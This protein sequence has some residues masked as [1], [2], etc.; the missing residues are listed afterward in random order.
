MANIVS[1]DSN[2]I[3]GSL[4]A[5]DHV[6]VY[7][8]AGDGK[9]TNTGQSV[10]I[11]GG[12]SDNDVENTGSSATIYGDAGND[13]LVNTGSSAIIDGGS[14]NDSIKSGG[15]NA[16]IT[17]GD[18][19]DVI[20][21][22][23]INSTIS[24]GDGNDVFV[25][26]NQNADLLIEDYSQVGD[27]DI[28]QVNS[29]AISGIT[30]VGSDLILSVNSGNHITL[31]GSASSVLHLRNDSGDTV[32]SNQS[33]ITINGTAKK[34][35]II[36]SG[37]NVLVNTAVGDDTINISGSGST[38]NSGADDDYINVSGANSSINAGDGS[39]TLVSSG[40]NNTLQAGNGNDLITITDNNTY[41]FTGGKDTLNGY[42]DKSKIKLEGDFVSFSG[43]ANSDTHLVTLTFS[44]TTNAVIGTLEIPDA[45]G[46]VLNIIQTDGTAVGPIYTGTSDKIDTKYNAASN[47]TFSGSDEDDYIVSSGSNNLIKP[48][49]GNDTVQFIHTSVDSG[50]VI[51]YTSGK[52]VV[53]GFDSIDA[54]RLEYTDGGY[55]TIGASYDGNDLKILNDSDTDVV[56]TLKNVKTKTVEVNRDVVNTVYAKNGAVTLNGVNT[57]DVFYYKAGSGNQLINGYNGNDS[58]VV[59]TDTNV[60]AAGSKSGNVIFGMG[61]GSSLTISGGASEK[62]NIVGYG[63]QEY[64]EKSIEVEDKDGDI[65]NTTLNAAVVTIDGATSRHNSVWLVGNKNNN[66]I[67]GTEKVGSTLHGGTGNDTLTGGTTSDIFIYS[68]GKDVIT[69]YFGKTGDLSSTIDAARYETDT[70]VISLGSAFS[71]YSISGQDVTFTIGTGSLKVLGGKNKLITFLDSKGDIDTGTT[72]IY[73]SSTEFI[74]TA[75]DIASLKTVQSTTTVG[76]IANPV[77]VTV[78]AADSKVTL[79]D[80][81]LELDNSSETDL[82]FTNLYITGNAAADTIKASRYGNDTLSGGG[83]KADTLVGSGTLEGANTGSDT[84][85][86]QYG[87]GKDV[88]VNYKEADRI[89]FT[90]TDTTLTGSTIKSGNVT[91]SV[92]D[93]KGKN[94]STFVVRDVAGKKI[95]FENEDGTLYSQVF[96]TTA[97]TIGNED[98]VTVNTKPNTAVKTI[99]ASARTTDAYIIGN[100]KANSIKGGTTGEFTLQGGAGKDTLTRG[101]NSKTTFAF[102]SN[103][104]TANVVTSYIEG[105]DT[106]KVLSGALTSTAT[107]KGSN[108]LTFTIGKTKVRVKDAKGKAITVVDANDT[109]TTQVYGLAS[110][111]VADADADENATVNTAANS[112]VV[113]I[114]AAE[115]TESIYLAGNSKGNV[116]L[117]GKGNETIA[118]A[119]GKDTVTFNT[120]D[121]SKHVIITDY[122]SGTDKIRLA[123]GVTIVA[124]ETLKSGNATALNGATLAADT[125]LLTLESDTGSGKIMTKL[126]VEGAITTSKKGKVTYGKL[127]V[128]DDTKGITYSQAYGVDSIAVANSDGATVDV[129]GNSTVKIINAKKRTTKSVILGNDNVNSIVGGTKADTIYAG[130]NGATINA[131]AGNDK[132]FGVISDTTRVVSVNGGKG[133]DTVVAGAGAN[134]IA[135]GAGNDVVYLSA[136]NSFFDSGTTNLGT[137]LITDYAAGKDK[138]FI[139]SGTYL[140]ASSSLAGGTDIMLTFGFGTGT[141]SGTKLVKLSSTKNKK[142]TIVDEATG[143]TTKQAYGVD[144]VA[145]ANG[146]AETV[147]GSAAYNS[148][149][150]IINAKKVTK[151]GLYLIG[152]SNNGSKIVGG[153]KADT[154]KSG[155]GNTTMTGGKGN[156]IFIYGG[157]NDTITDYSIT[158]KNNDV[159]NFANGTPTY[160]HVD[161][162]NVVLE[163]NSGTTSTN[164]L[165]IVNGKDKKI[166]FGTSFTFDGMPKDGVW[167]DYTE[168]VLTKTKSGSAVKGS[169][170]DSRTTLI[171]ATKYG[172]SITIV[173][174]DKSSTLNGSAK[175]DQI[176]GGG[177][178]D[179]ITTGKGKDT[180]SLSG[181]IDTITDYATGSDVLNLNGYILKSAKVTDAV[182]FTTVDKS[183]NEGTLRVEGAVSKKGVNQKITVYD[184][185][186]TTSQVYGATAITIGGS[187]GDVFDLS[188]DVNSNVT[189]ADAS[190]RKAT[191]S[192]RIISGS[193]NTELIGGAGADTLIGGDGGGKLTGGAG[194]DSLVGGKGATTFNPGKGDD[195]IVIST[196]D[197][198]SAATITY[199]A[200]GDKIYNYKLGDSINLADASTAKVKDARKNGNSYTINFK[201]GGSLDIGLAAG[202]S[203]SDVFTVKKE[204]T[205]VKKS[206]TKKGG[207]GSD[208][209][210]TVYDWTVNYYVSISGIKDA[211]YSTTTIT[212]V[213]T[214]AEAEAAAPAATA[215]EERYDGYEELYSTSELFTDDV[216]ASPDDLSEITTS[217]VDKTAIAVD[218]TSTSDLT[219]FKTASESLTTITQN[220]KK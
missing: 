135:T 52:D 197:G 183:G 188:T 82:Q 112:T 90:S 217:N 22:S 184:G 14:G 190:K 97:I 115:R 147:D 95:T 76:E 141:D 156:D 213:A 24:G 201:G 151:K 69:D 105:S 70:D 9:F 121:D 86:Y 212:K 168:L 129:N 53:I 133:N 13:T 189:K 178:N 29:G 215:Y 131:A 96:G 109:S 2:T 164:T 169:G 71:S 5:N 49:K 34:D 19:S 144:S 93:L 165:T 130:I 36:S 118:T 181:G 138:L 67:L 66:K 23:G 8:S 180:I 85:L 27:E 55:N 140:V 136:K 119:K 148:A 114:D 137:D 108:D 56:L 72:K 170:L 204:A 182:I 102:G 51:N 159:I 101:D 44:D 40:Y 194:N 186:R 220:N 125:M 211:V 79:I 202:V 43:F 187:D 218:L 59:S 143:L 20:E 31:K 209:G 89:F 68:S 193:K 4:N 123:S 92:T 62:L 192:I 32:S 54:V 172:S 64:G 158:S 152:N 83:T 21:V 75:D 106:I 113:T 199:T 120:L 18:G 1:N 15:A 149:L 28:L 208:S 166:T 196:E 134:T 63:A 110:I 57:S 26:S 153:S 210:T 77:I 48:G 207:T 206:G 84:Y 155:S 6:T 104:G 175:A 203:A 126:A 117:A 61:D 80:A 7:G 160:Y 214:K 45:T 10:I 91:F 98:Q 191:K 200:G 81:N 177:E 103:E 46:K 142:I 100:A 167:N 11:Y 25:Y 39:N 198:R 116:I 122:V 216:L 173:G 38:V 145:V 35:S 132:I 163:F 161:G 146:D 47:S 99:D 12:S 88:I 171:D 78:T 3:T 94:K 179:L 157:G 174:N 33:G 60:T 139:E 219:D 150:K 162:K 41:I 74:V 42:T 205:Q 73:R 128:I 17:G 195:H 30:T 37:G 16:L 185:T 65:I 124:A 127:T 176:S 154:I 107:I 87:Q 111:K 50:S 58:I